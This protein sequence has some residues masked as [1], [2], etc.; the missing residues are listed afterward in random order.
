ME[1]KILNFLHRLKA[2]FWLLPGLMAGAAILLS[3][4]S[5]ALD[6]TFLFQDGVPQWWLYSSGP[7]GARTVLSVIAGSMIT[8]AGV[9]FSITIVVLSYA[10]TAIL[11]RR[12][13]QIDI[14]VFVVAVTL[15]QLVSCKLLL[16][17][18]LPSRLNRFAPIAL[19]V[20]SALFVLFT[21]YTPQLSAFKDPV[22]GGYGIVR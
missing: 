16:A 12:L 21:F 4:I 5:I 22:S 8:V 2:S 17:S 9:V 20:L 14:A 6:K 19:A 18:P 15:G 7:D 1:I 13:L 10:Y 3:F 11:G